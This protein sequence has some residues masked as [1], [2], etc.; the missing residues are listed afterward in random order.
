MAD[1]NVAF[2]RTESFEGKNV[3]TNIDGDSG[4]ETWSGI[5]KAA[6]P[7]WAGWKILDAIPNKKSGK[8][9]T[10]DQLELLKRQLY[11]I[12]YW[13]KIWGDNLKNQKVANDMYDTAVNM[14][15]AM[16][17]RLAYRTLHM[18]ERTVMTNELLIKLNRI[19]T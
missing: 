5:S 4:K 16:S 19:R 10:N 7:S 2:T 3:W 15:V 13:D 11:K 18:V 1:F 9:Y 6:N 14:G 12:Q 8:R 17:I